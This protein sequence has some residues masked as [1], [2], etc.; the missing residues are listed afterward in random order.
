MPLRAR[1][2]Y[3]RWAFVDAGLSKMNGEL[4]EEIT[5]YLYKRRPG[6]GREIVWKQLGSLDILIHL[7]IFVVEC[8]FW[9]IE[10]VESWW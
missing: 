10:T 7:N 3:L 5:E 6:M 1:A 4:L 9:S 8:S 2:S